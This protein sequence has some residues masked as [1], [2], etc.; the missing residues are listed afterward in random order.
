MLRDRRAEFAIF[1]LVGIAGLGLTELILFI[2]TEGVGLDYRLSKL[3]A[4]G[5]VLMWNFGAR[6]FLLFRERPR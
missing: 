2:G 3:F 5:V 6:K 4:V 1:A